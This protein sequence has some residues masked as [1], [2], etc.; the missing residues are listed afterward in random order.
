MRNQ[1][2]RYDV[3]LLKND[4]INRHYECLPFIGENYERTRL[5]LIG[6]SHYVKKDEVCFVN[7]DD[8]YNSSYDDFEE[9]DYKVWINTR[10]VFE[11]RVYGES[12]FDT[13]FSTTATEIARIVNHTDDLSMEQK[14]EA[15]HQYAF[16][17]Y[18]KRP[19][20]E[21]GKTIRQLTDLDYKI[22]Y[23]ISSHIIET[24]I[25]KLII[26]LSKKAYYSFCDYDQDGRIM[27]KYQ[28]KCVSHPSCPW[29]NRKRRDGGCAKEDFYNYVREIL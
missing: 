23:D 20:Y 7:K 18:F 25:P 24:L 19:S 6:E 13:F 10:S 21:Q 2:E 1:Y 4:F 3:E 26:F 28:I 5:L 16:M 12:S 22:A 17:N 15:M 14:R 11:G 29:W 8:F 9:G 27:D